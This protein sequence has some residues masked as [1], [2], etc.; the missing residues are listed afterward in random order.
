MFKFGGAVPILAIVIPCYNEEE[1]L[2]ETTARISLVMENLITDQLV[3]PES[4]IL[5]VD[6][7]SAD[8]TW[9]IIE[10]QS[11]ENWYVKG[12]KLAGNV[13]H[14]NALLAGLKVAS[15]HSDC[16][17]SIDADLQDDITVIKEF[18]LKFHEGNDIV[19]GVREDRTTDSFFKKNT[20]QL[21]YRL[22]AAMGVNLV[23][24]HADYR[25]L[26]HRVLTQLSQF[27]ESNLFL[28]GIIPLIGFKSTKVYYKRHE[29][30]AGESKYPL[31]KMLSFAMEGITSFSVTPIRILTVIGIFFLLLSMGTSVYSLVQKIQGQTVSGW[32]SL[33]LSIWFIGGIQLMGLGLIGEYISKIY[34]EV[35]KRPKYHIDIDQYSFAKENADKS[36]HSPIGSQ[37]ER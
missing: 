2:Q 25:L 20:A 5:Y 15:E 27:Q 36:N 21:Y 32:T 35:K 9:K 23:Y 12:L 31:K 16:V 10:E 7:G 24:N 34:M 37:S 1:V 17:I 22:M 28:R 30:F 33:M 13:G 4:K 11:Q 26:S 3:S 6:D 19:Y 14:Q 29:R 8:R 18:I